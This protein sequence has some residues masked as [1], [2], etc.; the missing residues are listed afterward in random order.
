MRQHNDDWA[1]G[2]LMN[3]VIPNMYTGV[4]VATFLENI[5][6]ADG[7]WRVHSACDTT[8]LFVRVSA[9]FGSK[10]SALLLTKKRNKEKTDKKQTMKLEKLRKGCKLLSCGVVMEAWHHW[11]LTYVAQVTLDLLEAA[12][13]KNPPAIAASGNLWK[14]H[15]VFFS[16]AVLASC[17][18]EQLSSGWSGCVQIY[19]HNPACSP[20]RQDRL[21]LEFSV[22]IG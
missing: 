19:E 20:S 17:T 15:A 7:S 4:S 22:L 13:C 16:R 10:Q 9:N 5:T 11:Q 21:F 8:V 2:P 1:F 6:S 12:G 14:L 18:T 3:A